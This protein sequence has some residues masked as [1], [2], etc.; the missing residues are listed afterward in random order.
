MRVGPL[1]PADHQLVLFAAIR[2]LRLQA[3]PHRACVRRWVTEPP[4]RHELRYVEL[5]CLEWKANSFLDG[6]P[7]FG[8][9]TVVDVVRRCSF[10]PV[11]PEAVLKEFEQAAPRGSVPKMDKDGIDL[12]F[13][14]SPGVTLASHDSALSGSS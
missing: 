12:L 10:Y 8:L 7:Q 5:D 3:N 11:F 9:D 2:W 1:A 14:R 4:V 13:I 6:S